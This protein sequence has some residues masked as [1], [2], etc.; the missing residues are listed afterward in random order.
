MVDFK[1]MTEHQLRRLA[2]E[3]PTTASHPGAVER[4]VL[5]VWNFLSEKSAKSIELYNKTLMEGAKKEL[6]RREEEERKRRAKIEIKEKKRKLKLIKK[7]KKWLVGVSEPLELNESEGLLEWKCEKCGNK[8]RFDLKDHIDNISKGGVAELVWF[9]S[10]KK[11]IDGPSHW[12]I[13]RKIRLAHGEELSQ[14]L[15]K[16]EKKKK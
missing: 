12:N 5:V 7:L 9:C 1:K 10:G 6:A 4:M 14:K 16:E 8:A 15:L 13:D 2:S 11:E 3:Y